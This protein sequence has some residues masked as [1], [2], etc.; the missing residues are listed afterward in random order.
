[1]S[2]PMTTLTWTRG[3]T[4]RFVR[5]YLEMVVAMIVGMAARCSSPG[6]C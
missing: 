5:H 3:T 1:V 4:W 6:T 2:D